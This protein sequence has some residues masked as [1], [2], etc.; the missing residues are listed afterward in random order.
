MR[1][2][3]TQASSDANSVDSLICAILRGE[4]TPWPAAKGAAHVDTFVQQSDYHG[5]SALL[6]EKLYQA[7]GWPAKVRRAIHHRAIIRAMWELRHKHLLTQ[8]HAT[9]AEAGVQPLLLKGTALAYSLYP[10]PMLRGR[11]DTDIIIPP[12]ERRHVHDVLT[13]LGFELRLSVSGEFVSYQAKYVFAAAD[14]SRHNVDLHWRINNSEL[15]SHLFSFDELREHAIPL[16]KLCRDALGLS[17]V[18]ALLLACMHRAT[19]KQNP[20][21]ANGVAYYSADRIIW[22]YDI[23]LLAKSLSS[24][25]WHDVTRLAGSKGLCATCLDGIESARKRFYTTCPDFVLADLARSGVEE[26]PTTYLNASNLRQQWI[27]FCVL[28]GL[29]S[30]LRLLQEHVFPS[31]AYMRKKYPEA[32]PGWLPWLYARRVF[33]GLTKRIKRSRRTP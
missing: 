24:T 9:L 33:G 2:R 14:K 13:R 25:Q 10:K 32:Q 20:Y 26:L 21:Y 31:A 30:Q 17:P 5:V 6:N 11:G 23:H 28:E 15:L 29:S 3:G 16:P 22:L 18:H 4:R 7:Q 12:S 8:L 27:D 19:H 1:P